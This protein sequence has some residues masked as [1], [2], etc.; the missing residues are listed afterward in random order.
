MST[1]ILNV[2]SDESITHYTRSL[3]MS[4]K[5]LCSA[6]PVEL[7][8]LP[9]KKIDYYKCGSGSERIHSTYPKAVSLKIAYWMMLNIMET[10]FVFVG[11][12]GLNSTHVCVSARERS[13]V[14]SHNEI[15]SVHCHHVPNIFGRKSSHMSR[16]P[17]RSR[18]ASMP[19]H[20][21]QT[22]QPIDNVIGRI[23]TGHWGPVAAVSNPRSP[24]YCTGPGNWAFNCSQHHLRYTAFRTLCI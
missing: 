15:C 19:A 5:G 4:L 13:G 1:D 3:R 7:P 9:E 6:W 22:P 18:W 20:A 14:R 23:S 2:M 12:G 17:A 8:S 16:R 10:S 24:S 11:G 21:F